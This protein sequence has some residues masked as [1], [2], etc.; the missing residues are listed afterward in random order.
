MAYFLEFYYE[1][2]LPGLK[3]GYYANDAIEMDPDPEHHS[4]IAPPSYQA[5]SVIYSPS[6]TDGRVILNER[7]PR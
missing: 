3:P 4:V 2:E 7:S 1:D 6:E 5:E